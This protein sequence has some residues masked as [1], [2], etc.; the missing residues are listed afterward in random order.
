MVVVVDG[1]TEKLNY[2]D[3]FMLHRES[4][5]HLFFVAATSDTSLASLASHIPVRRQT[6]PDFLTEGPLQAPAFATT[7]AQKKKNT[8]CAVDGARREV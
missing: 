8:D 3:N 7:I 1:H 6:N 2:F 5:S 4:A